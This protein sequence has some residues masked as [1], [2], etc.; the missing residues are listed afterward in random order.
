MDAYLIYRICCINDIWISVPISFIARKTWWNHHKVSGFTSAWV[1]SASVLGNNL[2]PGHT[3]PH[4]QP[5][6]YL[7]YASVVAICSKHNRWFYS[8]SPNIHDFHD[9]IPDFQLNSIHSSL[10]FFGISAKMKPD[11][12]WPLR[13]FKTFLGKAFNCRMYLSV[14]PLQ[15]WPF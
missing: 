3:L 2:P 14:V 11:R 13:L 5:G 6:S 12:R 1:Q 10:K 4:R 9:F 7:Q 15:C 8:F